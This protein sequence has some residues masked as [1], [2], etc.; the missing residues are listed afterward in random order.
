MPLA[1]DLEVVTG[2]AVADLAALWEL[3]PAALEQ[4]LFDVM[5]SAVDTWTLAASAVAADWYDRER[6]QAEVS[7]AF[8]AIVEPLGDL[9]ALA[10][11]GWAAQ[12]LQTEPPEVAVESVRS[13]VEGGMSKRIV[14]SANYTITG[15]TVADPKARGWERVTRAGA[16]DFC[17]MVASRGGVFRESTARFACHERC[18]CRARPVWGGDEVDVYKYRPSQRTSRMDP[19]QRS[20]LNAAAREWIAANLK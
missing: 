15:S 14:N 9:G 4:A 19:E 7:G 16:C 1:A 18:Y 12:P 11:A 17:I 13:R 6:E 5:P 20:K 8:S 2:L 10:L 3:D